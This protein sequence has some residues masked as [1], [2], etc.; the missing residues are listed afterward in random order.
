MAGLDDLP[1][2]RAWLRGPIES[3]TIDDDELTVHIDAPEDPLDDESG[4][5]IH[6]W[7][8]GDELLVNESTT[9]SQVSPAKSPGRTTWL[10]G[11]SAAIALSAS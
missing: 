3:I 10:I 1:L 4:I 5:A 7:S 11:L 6:D 8:L 2:V 9:G